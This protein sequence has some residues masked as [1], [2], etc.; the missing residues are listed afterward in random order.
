MRKLLFLLIIIPSLSFGQDKPKHEKA[1]NAESVIWNY[2]TTN[3]DQ[4]TVELEFMR[5]CNYRYYKQNRTAYTL[6]GA[7]II[8]GSLPLII[9]EDLFENSKDYTA[10]TTNSA[11][12]SSGLSLIALIVL[13]DSDK[14]FKYSSFKPSIEGNSIVIRF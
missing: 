12:V 2:Q 4:S 3:V 13:I 8:V 6:W 14:W 10:F 9:N 11:I 7:G 5:Y 1:F